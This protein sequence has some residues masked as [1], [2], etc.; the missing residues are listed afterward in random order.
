MMQHEAAAEHAGLKI[1][2]TK[3]GCQVQIRGSGKFCERTARLAAHEGITVEGQDLADIVRDEQERM[4][5]GERPQAW[6]AAERDLRAQEL[7]RAQR[8]TRQLIHDMAASGDFPCD[9]AERARARADAVEAS[10]ESAAD[11]PREHSR[12]GGPSRPGLSPSPDWMAPT[13][14]RSGA[15]VTI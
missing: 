11:G 15:P 4:R 13:R 12:R 3:W 7:A 10:V 2:A 8:I 6:P 9:D 14:R 1:A 5:R